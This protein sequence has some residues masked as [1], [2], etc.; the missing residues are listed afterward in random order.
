MPNM[1]KSWV[2]AAGLVL[3]T[4]SALLTPAAAQRRSG[5]MFG[6]P[7]QGRNVAGQFDYY[8]L[9]LSWSPTHCASVQTSDNDPQCG[10]RDGRSYGFVLHGLWPQHERGWPEYCP[11]GRRPFVPQ[12]IIDGMMDIMPSPRLVIHEYR[13]HGVCADLDAAGYYALSRKL[14]NSIKVPEAYRNPFEN[15]MVSPDE[16]M[17]DFLAANPALKPDMMAVSCGGPGN[18]LREVRFC[19]SRSGEPRACGRNE[20]QRRMCSAQRM[21]VPPVRATKTEP[22]TQEERRNVRAPLPGARVIPGVGR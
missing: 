14:F 13:K 8:A 19:F 2:A 5:E 15:R 4:L 1:S 17:D 12:A 9:V 7:P 16:L 18:R 10:R 20:D 6:G 21:F 3:L 22:A 11:A